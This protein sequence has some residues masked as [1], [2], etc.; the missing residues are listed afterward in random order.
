MG[1]GKR[2]GPDPVIGEDPAPIRL[3]RTERDDVELDF[4]RFVD[5][6]GAVYAFAPSLTTLRRLAAGDL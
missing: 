3:A 1:D 6:T 2:D 4:R 5:T